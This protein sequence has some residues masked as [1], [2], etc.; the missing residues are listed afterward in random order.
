MTGTYYIVVK[1]RNSIETWSAQPVAYTIGTYDF[2]TAANKAYG[3]NMIQIESGKWAFYSGELN[4]DSNI[5]LLD[6]NIL[7]T[8]INNF[9]TGYMATDIN[10]DGNVDLLDTFPVETNISN[11]I[12]SSRP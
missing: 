4:N 5:D 8:D 1:H 11:F 9:L 6:M 10:G 3:N 12:F 2:T 7:S